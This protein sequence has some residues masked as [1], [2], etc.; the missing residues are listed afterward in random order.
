MITKLE[1]R[2]K[3][4]LSFVNYKEQAFDYTRDAFLLDYVAA[5]DSLY[6]GHYKPINALFIDMS[7]VNEV[8]TTMTLKYWNGSAFTDVSGLSD[9]SLALTRSGHVYWD[10]NQTT[11]TKTTI[12]GTETYWYKIDFALDLTAETEIGGLNLLFSTD[13]MLKEDEPTIMSYIPTGDASFVSF[14]QS[15]KKDLIQNLRNKGNRVDGELEYKNL[16]EFDLL[17][18]HEIANASKYLTLSKIFTW[19]SDNVDDKYKAKK[20]DYWAKYSSAFNLSFVSLDKDDDGLVD[21][22]EKV[23]IQFTEIVMI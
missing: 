12:N 20:D 17:D 16:T 2:F 23:A 8:A 6:V 5:E 3:D 22:E 21:S 10:R 11:E 15:A 19:L 1:V 7:V 18:F 13:Q 9:E 14:H 4:N